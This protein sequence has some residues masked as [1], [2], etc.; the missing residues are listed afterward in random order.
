MEGREE[1]GI[2]RRRAVVA[3]AAAAGSIPLARA[4]AKA[5]PKASRVDVAVVGAGLSGLTAARTL[6]RAGRS[7]LVLEARDRVGGR[8]FDH[9]IGNGQV[10]EMGG[11]WAGPGQ[12]RVLALAEE[13]GVKTFE[14]FAQG[15]SIYYRDGSV[16]RY[17]G[18]IP[19]ANAAS[20]AELL[21]VITELNQMAESVPTERPWEA[22]NAGR[23]DAESILSWVRGR[24]HTAEGLSLV[25]LAVS[26]V[27]GENPQQISLLDL[28]RSITGVGG[29]FFTLIGDAQSIRFEGGPQRLSKKLAK[30]LGRHVRLKQAVRSIEAGRKGVTLHARSDVVHAKRVI[31]TAPAPVIAQIRFRPNLPPAYVQALQRT[32]MGAVTKVN[33]IYDRPFWREAGLSGTVTSDTGPVRIVYDNSPPDGRPGVLVGFMEGDD[34]RAYFDR[35]A[36]SRRAGALASLARY[37]GPEAAHPR[38]YVDM[39]WAQE[40]YSGGAYGT[41]GPPGTLTSLGPL[42]EGPA[43]RVHFAGDGTSGTWPGYMDGAI[44]S[45][46]RAA[47]EVIAAL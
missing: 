40:R 8:N 45:G 29:D 1:S 26:G 34:S 47:A 13:L 10:V 33:A 7:V 25:E 27:Y 3:G 15:A 11:Q 30:Q 4:A 46:E 28:L 37:F 41:Y 32:P 9:P 35:S 5:P 23:D 20:L 36:E 24:V 16:Q 31:V 44:R 43:G 21:A 19:P 14:T 2:T 18:D 22:P 6:S 42:T 39:V 17:D 38:D 12:D